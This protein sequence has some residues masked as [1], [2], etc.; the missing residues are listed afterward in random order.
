MK[1]EIYK[2]QTKGDML[3]SQEKTDIRQ[4]LL[5]YF[6]DLARMITDAAS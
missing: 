6:H 4:N 5:R 1:D 3:G 2:W